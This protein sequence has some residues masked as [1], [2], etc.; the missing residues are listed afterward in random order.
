MR[1]SIVSTILVAFISGCLSSDEQ[2]PFSTNSRARYLQKLAN[3]GYDL[4]IMD[5]SQNGFE[6]LKY[7]YN[8]I[9]LLRAQSNALVFV[10][11]PLGVARESYSY[12]DPNWD[13]NYDG[14]PDSLAPPWLIRKLQPFGVD[15]LVRY[16]DPH[17]QE[18]SALSENSSLSTIL[19]AGYDG[20]YLTWLNVWNLQNEI[21]NADIE[22]KNFVILVIDSLRNRYPWLGFIGQNCTGL[23]RFPDLIQKIDGAI[24]Y[25]FV[26]GYNGQD[27]M[28]VPIESRNSIVSDLSPIQMSGKFIGV[29]DF[30]FS[31]SRN[32]V[33]FDDFI[34][35][36]IQEGILIANQYQYNYYASVR[37]MNDLTIIPGNEPT[38]NPIPIRML[39]SVQEFCIQLR[40][41]VY[42]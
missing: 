39:S 33:V 13:R 29:V 3:S 22:M 9:D 40:P 20:C 27:G 25:E 38:S 21:P 18:I 34:R 5:Y 17:Y 2:N 6:N 4:I 24:Q 12:W 1:V 32:R 41:S 42:E 36:S 15:W 31:Y 8:E 16:W 28:P 14:L 35:N 23:T 26:W 10:E 37:E 19:Q 30:P 7:S 11:Y